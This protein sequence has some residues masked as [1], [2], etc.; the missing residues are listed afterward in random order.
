MERN[1]A[2]VRAHPVATPLKSFILYI[3]NTIQ[4]PNYNPFRIKTLIFDQREQNTWINKCGTELTWVEY[5]RE[6]Y[7]HQDH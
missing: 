6:N 3:L 1:H 4:F 7:H 2:F 5:L